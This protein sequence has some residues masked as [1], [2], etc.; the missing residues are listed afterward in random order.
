MPASCDGSVSRRLR[1]AANRSSRHAVA[2]GPGERTLL[3]EKMDVSRPR[4]DV[5]TSWS[6]RPGNR[7]SDSTAL[8][9]TGRPSARP[10]TWGR[11]VTRVHVPA[12]G[13]NRSNW[14]T[15]RQQ[16]DNSTT[17]AT[18]PA[19]R[20]LPYEHTDHHS[21]TLHTQIHAESHGAP[22]QDRDT[23]RHCRIPAARAPWR[24]RGAA[25][26]R[27][28]PCR[29]CVAAPSPPSPQR[30]RS[31][32]HPRRSCATPPSASPPAAETHRSDTR[33]VMSRAR[34]Q[35]VQ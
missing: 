23:H 27:R 32:R 18:P 17:T 1:H 24:S 9:I 13:E 33:D 11:D 8:V 34:H 14:T 6:T 3:P 7:S 31:C 12:R 29:G 20:Q 2:N 16:H 21:R 15:A 25:R 28:T 19:T 35:Q 26:R 5:A 22:R 10:R 30:R 4:M